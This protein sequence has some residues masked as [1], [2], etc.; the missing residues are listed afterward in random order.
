ME[1]KPERLVNGLHIPITQLQQQKILDNGS[2]LIFGIK[3]K[4]KLKYPTLLLLLIYV[5]RLLSAYECKNEYWEEMKPSIP[6][7]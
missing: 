4:R 1:N 7:S 6:S 3:L 2:L 5:T